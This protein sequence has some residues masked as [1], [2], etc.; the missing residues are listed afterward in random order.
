VS[1]CDG[2]AEPAAPTAT[3]ATTTHQAGVCSLPASSKTAR[4][5][6]NGP[7]S[8]LYSLSKQLL[9]VFPA[10]KHARRCTQHMQACRH[11]WWRQSTT[12][13]GSVR[14]QSHRPTNTNTNIQCAPN[15]LPP[16]THD[17]LLA[18]QADD[19]GSGMTS[20][21]PVTRYQ[22]H[23]C[24]LQPGN[25]ASGQGLHAHRRRIALQL[26]LGKHLGFSCFIRHP[27]PVCSVLGGGKGGWGVRRGEQGG[28]AGETSKLA[29]NTNGK[30]RPLNA[31]TVSTST[32]SNEAVQKPAP[33]QTA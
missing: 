28:R 29:H 3:T 27:E 13:W 4:N 12:A 6:L 2:K 21:P 1:N 7:H 32:F 17:C 10:R 20:R 16:H 9:H 30:Q 19:S 11:V 25:E 18:A 8:V 14:A 15:T 24:V 22:P 31:S 33:A 23:H 26:T 5:S